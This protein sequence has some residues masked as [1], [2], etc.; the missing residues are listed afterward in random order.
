MALSPDGRWLVVSN[1]GVAERSVTDGDA[2]AVLLL[3]SSCCTTVI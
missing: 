1:D 3:R 2:V